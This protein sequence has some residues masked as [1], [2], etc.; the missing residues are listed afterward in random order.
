[1]KMLLLLVVLIVAGCAT[2][3]EPR[4]GTDSRRDLWQERNTD[5]QRECVLIIMKIAPPTATKEELDYNLERCLINNN[6]FI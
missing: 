3:Q 5:I 4:T 2:I 6:A 1:M